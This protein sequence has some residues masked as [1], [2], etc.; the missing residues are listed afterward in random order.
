MV[1]GSKYWTQR[2][3]DSSFYDIAHLAMIFLNFGSSVALLLTAFIYYY[4]H[5]L[6][7]VHSSCAFH[8]TLNSGLWHGTLAYRLLFQ[9]EIMNSKPTLC[10]SKGKFQLL[11]IRINPLYKCSFLHIFIVSLWGYVGLAFFCWSAIL[12][13]DTWN[14]SK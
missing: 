7:D 6:Q 3:K 9:F 13:W 12:S 5:S 1:C 4:L 10:I 11:L 8:F 14:Q 2:P